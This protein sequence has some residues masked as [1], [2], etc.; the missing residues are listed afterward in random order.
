MGAD[1]INNDLT[2][3]FRKQFNVLSQDPNVLD[4]YEAAKIATTEYWA[5]NGGNAPKYREGQ[6]DEDATNP[7]GKFTATHNGEFKLY[8]AY[9]KA[10]STRFTELNKVVNEQEFNQIKTNLITNLNKAGESSDV[11][12]KTSLDRLLNTPEAVISGSE[13][14]AVLENNQISQKILT[15]A[16]LLGV[17]PMKLIKSQYIAL[18]KDDSDNKL[19]NLDQSDIENFV[20]PLLYVEEVLNKTKNTDLLYLLNREGI[21][22]FSPKQATRLRKVL[23]AEA[24]V[25]S[26]I[27]QADFNIERNKRLQR[28]KTLGIKNV[29]ASALESDEALDKFI[30]KQGLLEP[31]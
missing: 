15:Q 31:N 1:T 6:K 7:R 12:G 20:N 21:Q 11:E 19:R 4:P 16:K 23:A 26:T 29:P 27:E 18:A 24:E 3:Y 30:T 10:K 14:K 28:L 9:Q 17:S 8:D 13:L 2:R 25:E 22:N 5:R